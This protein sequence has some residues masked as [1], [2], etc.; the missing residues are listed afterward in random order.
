ML[1]AAELEC[2][3]L[4]QYMLPAVSGQNPVFA[5]AMHLVTTPPARP[6]LP[7]RSRPLTQRPLTTAARQAA[8]RGSQGSRQTAT[9]RAATPVRRAAPLLACQS[10]GETHPAGA[11]TVHPHS[12]TSHRVVAFALCKITGSWRI[13]ISRCCGK[14]SCHRIFSDSAGARMRWGSSPRR[15]CGRAACW[16]RTPWRRWLSW[17]RRCCGSWTWSWRSRPF[18]RR[19][20]VS[21]HPGCTVLASRYAASCDVHAVLTCSV[22]MCVVYTSVQ[23]AWLWPVKRGWDA[24]HLK[25]STCRHSCAHGAAHAAAVGGAAVSGQRA[26][27]GAA[28]GLWLRG[29]PAACRQ[30]QAL[31]D[32]MFAVAMVHR[33]AFSVALSCSVLQPSGAELL[34]LLQG[35]AAG[36]ARQAAAKAAGSVRSASASQPGSPTGP[37]AQMIHPQR[38]TLILRNVSVSQMKCVQAES[39]CQQ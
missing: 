6:P 31:G 10:P 28:V 35:W 5:T 3:Q 26:H 17:A 21:I 23:L 1:P 8:E 22:H 2:R 9:R 4:I 16:R 33:Q 27:R 34:E 14:R 36:A 11:S 29:Q 13:P 24:L 18:P 7:M 30:P 37:E 12:S 20:A 38:I 32:A 19:A 25:A 15:C 39:T